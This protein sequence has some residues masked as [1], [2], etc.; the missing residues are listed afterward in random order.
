[1]GLSDS[2]LIVLFTIL[3]NPMIKHK[4]LCEVASRQMKGFSLE[5]LCEVLETLMPSDYV[6]SQMGTEGS[7]IY[8]ATIQG[9]NL[10][11]ESSSR[12]R[13]DRLLK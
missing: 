5:L 2:Q 4:T 12:S 8:A 6:A 3:C 7:T 9:V 13:L 10:C 11:A 1:M